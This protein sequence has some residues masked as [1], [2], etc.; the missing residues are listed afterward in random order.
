MSSYLPA[1]DGPPFSGLEIAD[2]AG[3]VTGYVID[4]A[5]AP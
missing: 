1:V 2:S 4:P 3:M 5:A